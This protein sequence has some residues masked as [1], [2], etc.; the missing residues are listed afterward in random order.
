MLTELRD[1]PCSSSDSGVERY[2][3]DRH[4]SW[5]A[6]LNFG[7]IGKPHAITEPTARA[8]RPANTGGLLRRMEAVKFA[9]P[10]LLDAVATVHLGPL[11]A[12]TERK[13]P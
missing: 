2:I 13:P 5:P 4:R 12:T 9:A 6:E 1:P 7:L 11:P 3:P 10:E 8:D